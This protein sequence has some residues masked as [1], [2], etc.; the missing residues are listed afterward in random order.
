M[1]RRGG[2]CRQALGALLAGAAIAA[3]CSSVPADELADRYDIDLANLQLDAAEPTTDAAADNATNRADPDAPPDAQLTIDPEV[4]IGTLDNGLTYY[5]RRNTTPGSEMDIR[6]VVRAGSLQQ[7]DPGDGVAHFLEHMLFNGTEAFPGNELDRTLQGFGL[8]FGADSNAYTGYHETV[9]FLRLSTD[10]AETIDTGFTVLAEWADRAL[11]DPAEVVAERGVVRDEFRQGRETVD[12][13]VFSALEEIYTEGTPYEGARVIS[14]AERIEATEAAAL[15]DYYDRWYH[16]ANMAIVAVGDLPVDVMRRQI[17]DRFNDLTARTGS[18]GTPQHFTVTPEPEPR[19]DVIVHPDQVGDSISLDWLRPAFDESTVAGARTRLLDDLIAEML[20]ERTSAAYLDGSLVLDASPFMSTFDIAAHLRYFGTNLRAP[21]LGEGYAQ[22]LGIVHG[23]AEFGFTPAELAQATSVH[24]ATLDEWEDTLGTTIDSVWADAYTQHFL[25]GD[26]AE[27]PAITIA[28]ERAI[29][30]SVTTAEVTA[31][32]AEV[33]AA[34]GPIAVSIGADAAALPDAATLA[35]IAK[36]V[37]PIAPVDAVTDLDQLMT[38]PA[39]VGPV[40]TERRPGWSGS[41]ITW[42]YANGATVVFEPSDIA[43]GALDLYAESLGGYSLLPDGSAALVGLATN[44]VAQSGLGDATVSQVDRLLDST[45]ITFETFID[46]EI[47]GFSGASTPEDA[48]TLFQLLH[49]SV[50]EPRVDDTAFRA[51]L[52]DGQLLH[53][54]ARTDPFTLAFLELTRLLTGSEFHSWI[55]TQAQLDT[56]SADTLLDVYRSRLSTVDDLVVSIVGDLDPDV[57]GDLAD[58]YIG[59]L[60]AGSADTFVDT[61]GSEPSTVLSADVALPEGTANGGVYLAW[62]DQGRWDEL[63]LVNA[64]VLQQILTT[65]IF[66]TIREELGASYGGGASIELTPVPRD[67]ITAILWLDGDPTRLDEMVDR[68]LAELAELRAAGPTAGELSRARA[69]LE[70]EWGFV[71]NTDFMYEN[72]ELARD[73]E[74]RLLTDENRLDLLAEVDAGSVQ[75]LVVRVFD[76]GA[77]VEVR[78]S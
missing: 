55:P 43:D 62:I 14:S 35:Q 64:R 46:A 45:S 31:R 12:G 40:E 51:V 34:S 17:E 66:E 72:V 53:D 11:I 69:V 61:Q 33:L 70:D 13:I 39:P 41:T 60:P 2:P 38:P 74:S 50:T 48:E 49:L 18:P 10:D 23:A 9:Y 27:A 37:E 28:R 15:R 8:A 47:E 32:W 44:A 73:P 71:Y 36:T 6:L 58:R 76:P 77:Y 54:A 19:T 21:D 4:Q 24:R 30:D 67:A 56:L 29:L 22:Y 20:T 63:D 75:D 68:T 42:R 78:R 59:T 52:V 16:P 57:I 26:G 65:R 1:H 5:I 25:Y 3:A 7:A